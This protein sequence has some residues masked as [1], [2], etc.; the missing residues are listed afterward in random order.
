MRGTVKQ[1][2]QSPRLAPLEDEVRVRL[3]ELTDGQRGLAEWVLGHRDEVVF[4]STQE[5]ARAAGAS[6]AAV[7]RFAQ[8]LGFTGYPELRAKLRREM[9]VRVGSPAIQRRSSASIVLDETLPGRVAELD[10]EII[11]ATGRLNPWDRYAQVIDLLAR[12]ERVVC[13]GH[14]SSYPAAH[15]LALELS[16]ALGT[17]EVLS[18]GAGD[19]FF[20]LS[21]LTERDVLV[22]VSYTRYLRSTGEALEV[23]KARGVPTVLI[24]DSAT[25]AIA[26]LASVLLLAPSDA[27]AFTW[28]YVGV[29]SIMNVL[30]AGVVLRAGA[31]TVDRL[32]QL[33]E[34]TNQYRTLYDPAQL[35]LPPHGRPLT[36]TKDPGAPA[37]GISVSR[38]PQRRRRPRH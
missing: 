14:G 27:V 22:A 23:A 6:D 7:V 25:S 38:S 18:S 5:L 13:V 21:T 20:R 12:A 26:P 32:E 2:L 37:R 19:M 29:L 17:G 28:S 1:T 30:L 9:Q 35:G 10:R 31:R 36:L 8:A 4:M 33:N 3:P 24:T 34:L 16:Q 15:Y 11:D